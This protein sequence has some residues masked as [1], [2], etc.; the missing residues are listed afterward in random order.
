MELKTNDNRANSVTQV[1]KLTTMTYATWSLDL[2]VYV[3]KPNG[4]LC[5]K[6]L[7]KLLQCLQEE[8]ISNKLLV[9]SCARWITAEG[10]AR[11]SKI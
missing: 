3:P 6:R 7:K 2:K 1:E 10:Q 9:Q 8:R 5:K 4:T 11:C